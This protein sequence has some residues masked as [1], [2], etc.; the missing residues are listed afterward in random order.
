MEPS[1]KVIL[2]AKRVI[3]TTVDP[4]Y[5]TSRFV[6]SV[7]FIAGTSD[8]RKD[9]TIL[10]ARDSNR[11]F[12]GTLCKPFT[13]Y[14]ISF[15]WALVFMRLSF[16]FR[17]LYN[18]FL[19]LLPLGDSDRSLS[20]SDHNRHCSLYYGRVFGFFLHLSTYSGYR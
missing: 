15:S 3:D 14:T 9:P 13:L 4:L 16:F 17:T 6:K 1:N 20:P 8:R 19:S 10:T 7:P 12:N 18:A 11:V 5:T 2:E